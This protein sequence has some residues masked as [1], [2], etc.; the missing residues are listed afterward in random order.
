VIVEEYS[1]PEPVS[2]VQVDS[3]RPALIVLSA[4]SA[5]QLKERARQ[6]LAHIAASAYSD[7]AL[8]DIGYTLQVGREAM[9]HRLAFTAWS[10]D[11]LTKKLRAYLD[12]EIAGASIDE[13]YLGEM[14]RGNELLAAL[15]SD[16]DT[17]SLVQ[18]WLEKGKY[19]KLLELWV[20]GLSFN[21]LDLYQ[22]ESDGN[23][24]RPRR[25]PLPAYPFTRESYWIVPRPESPDTSSR[26][27]YVL[28][29]HWELAPI[30][31][32]MSASSRS[33]RRA[34]IMCTHET[35]ELA[36]KLAA[37]FAA[38][39][40]LNVDG[41]L[42]GDL[43]LKKY[44]CW[45][46]IVGCGPT[47]K[48]DNR[49]IEPLQAW[50][51][52]VPGDQPALL[53]V[54]SDLEAHANGA[55][56]LSGADRVGLY[57]MLP[58]EYRRMT[59]RHVDLDSAEDDQ[60]AMTHIIAECSSAANEV[61]V[62][63][64]GGLRYR[65]ALREEEL[66]TSR[67][68]SDKR[69]APFP[70]DHVLLITGGTRGI[71]FA[72][73][74]HFVRHHGVKQL[75]L[76]GRQDFPP[77]VEW[78]RFAKE[79]SAIARKIQA[80]LDLEAEGA[81][82]RVSSVPLVDGDALGR[83]IAE[84]AQS[85]GRI[86]GVL[87]CAGVVDRENPAFVSKTRQN[88][89]TVS[90]PKV[91]GLDHLLRS[92][93]AEPMRFILLFS[94]VAAI[95]PTLAVG[96][97]D[98]AL[99]NAYM[100]YVAEANAHRLPI[101]SIQWPSWSE[102]GMGKI[103]SPVYQQLG[104]LSCSDA[105]GL[106][107]LDRLLESNVHSVVLPALVDKSRWHVANLLRH[108]PATGMSG[109]H[110]RDRNGSGVVERNT[111]ISAP[112]TAWLVDIVRET[113]G[114]DPSKLE[115]DRP[116]TEYGADSIMLLQLV[117]TV[118]KRVGEE[119]DP[120]ILFEHQTIDAFAQWLQSKYGQIDSAEAATNTTDAD[121]S[122]NTVS[123][124]SSESYKK[125][126]G[127]RGERVYE[128][129]TSVQDI[130]VI[131]LACRFPGAD[132]IT[133]FWTLLAE[134]RCGIRPVPEDRW[135]YKTDYH[136]GVLNNV[137]D[138]DPAFFRIAQADAQAMDPQALLLLEGSLELWHHAGYQPHELKG[139]SIG[140][141][142]GA[143]YQPVM[144]TQ[145]LFAA[146]NPI[147][148]VGANYLSANISRVFDLRGPSMVIDTACSSALV[149]M[150]MAIKSLR[151]GEIESALVSGVSLLNT[152]GA[153]RLFE[154]RGILSKGTEFHLFDRRTSGTVLGEGVGLVWLK[155]LEQAK[156]DGDSIYAV[157]K[158]LAINN[159]GQ[160]AGP[161]APNWQAQKDVMRRA[162]ESSG[163]LP[164]DIG[165][166]EVNGSGTEV[167]DLLEL[168]AIK[169]VYRNSSTLP[170]ELGSMKPN[171]GHPL[172][173]E[174]IASFIKTVLVLHHGRRV[175][176]LSAWEPM[177]HFD[178]AAS[179]FFFT[180]SLSPE[181]DAPSVMALNC[182]ADGGTN[183]HVILEKWRESQ[184]ERLV[185]HPI[186]APV[187]RRVRVRQTSPV[188]CDNEVGRLESSRDEHICFWEHPAQV[189][190]EQ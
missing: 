182:F 13:L 114:L 98:Y 190:T 73:A 126:D 132:S 68:F 152:E 2:E 116:L 166:I 84:I 143:R 71:G 146:E 183:A 95:V 70:D 46:D 32:Q 16:S 56:N 88:M 51:A 25:I 52:A 67:A 177:P 147:M 10:V 135:G 118:G 144:N 54:T 22:P 61:E 57:R 82:V 100:D 176:F 34:L 154:Q 157:V 40:I 149:A 28:T 145:L 27:T 50:I 86:A 189:L 35:T 17:A 80:I 103:A 168:K 38:G 163:K 113:L 175:P 24:P 43:D 170:C 120:S 21:W 148:V 15:N 55:I 102:S 44:D 23:R 125:S 127:P 119:I 153:L 108:R 42:P 107:M 121:A 105:E 139:K 26:A 92:L 62:C 30:P 140:V 123:T 12:D 7:E 151:R 8:V 130:A 117:R 53:C 11:E 142:V 81:S 167:T 65:S 76:M 31:D 79:D 136:A 180:R 97:S 173:A 9:E 160:S 75:V 185:R 137:T 115:L 59:G 91:G 112:M 89:D 66:D 172:C 101:K 186:E 161:A 93:P 33:L 128:A 99:S 4:K 85:M 94:S 162:L 77:R 74:K 29:K 174:G 69:V 188:S 124:N 37:Q 58:S 48:H 45:I 150:D 1:E 83:E 5:E 179:P 141:Y 131:G 129:D 111:T 20:K 134:G 49:W 164:G 181:G 104:F 41:T 133:E 158:G 109:A 159:D 138:F 171:I 178:L 6:L 60:A 187:L 78:S 3:T 72:C 39:R 155:T 47:K 90:E 110:G 106:E 169:A 165:C 19:A 14:K 96:Q 18:T 63:Y 87:H 64:R 122:H 156:R 184:P 36:E